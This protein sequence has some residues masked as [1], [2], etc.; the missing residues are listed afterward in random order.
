MG[1]LRLNESSGL[2]GIA[3][4]IAHEAQSACL[5][6]LLSVHVGEM[7]ASCLLVQFLV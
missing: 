1:V 7:A 4:H 5:W 6:N 3:D 2:V